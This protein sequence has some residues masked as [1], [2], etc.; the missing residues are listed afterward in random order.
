MGQ[1]NPWRLTFRQ[2]KEQLW[3]VDVGSSN[4]EEINYLLDAPTTGLVNRGWPCYEG[5][6]RRV[7][8]QPAW[9]PLGQADLRATSTP[10]GHAGAVKAPFFSYRTRT[11]A[12]PLTPGENCPVTH[13]SAM[14]GVAFTPLGTDWPASYQ[15]S[16]FFSDFLRGCIW[17]LEKDASGQPDPGKVQVFAQTAGA[18]PSWSPGRAVTSTTST[19]ARSTATATSPAPAASTAST[20]SVPRRSP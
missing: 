16:L 5:A 2:G 11:G 7:A 10:T 17:R 18:P 12:G 14:S 15:D 4:W 20:T 13:S 19:T 9:E 3:S 1:R 8:A 6:H